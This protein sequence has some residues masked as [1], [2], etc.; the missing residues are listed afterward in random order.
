MDFSN[1]RTK[2]NS[3]GL[4]EKYYSFNVFFKWRIHKFE[5]YQ[6][7]ILEP[8]SPSKNIF[9]NNQKKLGQE[10]RVFDQNMITFITRDENG[11]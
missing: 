9:K 8:G 10:K 2:W 11:E 5:K 3:I 4:P 7:A 1:V 6:I